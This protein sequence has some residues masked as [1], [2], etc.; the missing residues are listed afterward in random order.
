MFSNSLLYWCLAKNVSAKYVAHPKLWKSLQLL[1][2]VALKQA[3][4]NHG[5]LIARVLYKVPHRRKWKI[6]WVVRRRMQKRTILGENGCFEL[7]DCTD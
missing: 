4:A 5:K 2:N 7:N 1:G 3:R 6:K